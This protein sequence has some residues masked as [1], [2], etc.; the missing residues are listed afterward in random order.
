MRHKAV[1]KESSG[2]LGLISS[3][4][5]SWNKSKMCHSYLTHLLY[6]YTA[7]SEQITSSS[8]SHIMALLYSIEESIMSL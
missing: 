6:T 8:L 7:T 1:I 5:M 3:D 2:M 4:F